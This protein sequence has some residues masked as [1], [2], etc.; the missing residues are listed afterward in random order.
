[1]SRHLEAAA[2]CIAVAGLL[3]FL[4]S[5]TVWVNDL[6]GETG[7]VDHGAQIDSNDPTGPI[8]GLRE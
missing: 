1:M 7:W 5:A 6:S 8:S 2:W 3:F 4:A